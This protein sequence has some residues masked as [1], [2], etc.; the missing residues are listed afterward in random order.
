MFLLSAAEMH[1]EP[2]FGVFANVTTLSSLATLFVLY[3]AKY[4][5]TFC[6]VFAG[7]AAP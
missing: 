7:K 1:P 4:V 3:C 5:L 2:L 6:F